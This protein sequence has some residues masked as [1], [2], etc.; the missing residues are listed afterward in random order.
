MTTA[1]GTNAG[2][3]RRKLNMRAEGINMATSEGKKVR[4]LM[5]D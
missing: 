4:T 3:L 1:A 2:L 5:M